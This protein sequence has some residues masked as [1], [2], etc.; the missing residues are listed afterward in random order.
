M[1]SNS[2]TGCIAWSKRTDD[3]IRAAWADGTS[4]SDIAVRLSVSEY[5]VRKQARALGLPLRGH[6]VRKSAMQGLT[7]QRARAVED[8]HR[9]ATIAFELI[10]CDWA[11]RHP[12]IEICGYRAAA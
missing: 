6:G 3:I 2:R 10:Y 4:T 12:G 7:M 8:A 1:R 5:S 11:D 9:A